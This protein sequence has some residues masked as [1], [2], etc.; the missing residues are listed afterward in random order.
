[1]MHV[2]RAVYIGLE[3]LHALIGVL[4]IYGLLFSNDMRILF[5]SLVVAVLAIMVAQLTQD[6]LLNHLQCTL[7]MHPKEEKS[8]FQRIA[9]GVAA[10]VPVDPSAVYLFL[11]VMTYLVILV[12]F[13][14]LYDTL[15]RIKGF[16]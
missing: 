11:L 15:S 3:V 9:H 12:G 8:R 5:A 6:T 1:M 10:T 7:E 13:Y 16:L 2:N 14:R 4:L